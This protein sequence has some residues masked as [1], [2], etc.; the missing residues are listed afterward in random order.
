MENL[1]VSACLL[2][3]NC[4]YDGNNNLIDQLEQLKSRYNLIP[5]C[6][7]ILGGMPTPR[8]PV[9]ISQGEVVNRNG[10]NFTS[11]FHKGARETLKIAQVCECSK[12]LLQQRSPSCGHGKIYDGTFTKTLIEGNGIAADL[13][14]HA[15][16]AIHSSGDI[17]ALLEK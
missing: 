17:D 8:L 14:E 11:Q 5:V 16:I 15:G 7:E 12:A 3:I 1:L 10:E 4:R 6:P 13:L 9:E 2:G